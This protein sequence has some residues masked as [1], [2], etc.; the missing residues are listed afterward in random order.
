MG[1]SLEPFSRVKNH[2]KQNRNISYEDKIQAIKYKYFFI[3]K[4]MKK[5]FCL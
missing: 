2:I 3:K 5:L 1:K 4:Q